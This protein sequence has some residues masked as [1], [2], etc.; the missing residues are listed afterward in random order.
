MKTLLATQQ[1]TAQNFTTAPSADDK[2]TAAQV[3]EA[4]ALRSEKL[5][6]IVQIVVATADRMITRGAQILVRI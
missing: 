4:K 3:E 6:V 1:E 5:D 2:R